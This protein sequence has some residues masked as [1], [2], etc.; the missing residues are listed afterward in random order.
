MAFEYTYSTMSAAKRGA[1][2]AKL[3]NPIFTKTDEGKVFVT[4]Q[5]LVA[6]PKQNKRRT[7]SSIDSPVAVFR[8][9]FTA[10]FGK[11]K[12]GELIKLAVEHGVAKNTA[13]THYQ[14]WSK[15]IAK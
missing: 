8:E 11:I 14:T 15:K 1:V 3:T 6:S 12:R 2:R 9:L 5:K 10:N 7:V 4:E 13:A